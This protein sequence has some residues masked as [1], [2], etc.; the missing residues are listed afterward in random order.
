[1]HTV[2][3]CGYALI[4]SAMLGFSGCDSASQHPPAAS[5]KPLEML[6]A[7]GVGPINAETRFNLHDITMAFQSLNVTQQSNYTEG[8]AY[9]V[10]TVKK[11]TKLLLTINPD[12]KQENIFSVMVHDNLIGNRLGHHIGM[13]FA[14]IYTPAEPVECAG[15]AAEFA[16]KV[17]CYAPQAGNVLYQFK[18]AWN[19]APGQVP[20]KEVLANWELDAIVWKPR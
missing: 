5:V 12:A 7:D 13:R 19:G 18:G 10:I 9:P 11:D 8:A 20:P 3:A 4:V 14:D 15:G 2:R 16:G 1:M 17:L 6:S